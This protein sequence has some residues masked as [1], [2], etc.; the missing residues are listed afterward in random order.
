MESVM[1]ILNLFMPQK[2]RS[3]SQATS[4]EIDTSTQNIQ[5]TDSASYAASDEMEWLR[6]LS[7]PIRTY[8]KPG[9]TLR[10]EHKQWLAARAESRALIAAASARAAGLN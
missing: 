8:R 5:A 9:V 3:S 1:G 4:K 7:R 2:E 6:Y 10:D